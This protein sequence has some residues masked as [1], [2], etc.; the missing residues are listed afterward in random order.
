MTNRDVQ[1]NDFN[2]KDQS[3]K[4][5]EELQMR[6]VLELYTPWCI[7]LTKSVG[8]YDFDMSITKFGFNK[9][10]EHIAEDLGLIELERKWDD[11]WLEDWY[12][13]SILKRKVYDYDRV[14]EQWLTNIH[15]DGEETL[16]VK[17]D[18]YYKQAFAVTIQDVYEH[19]IK[20]NRGDGS[21]TDS[22]IGIPKDAPYV[23]HDLVQ[24]GQRIA[25]GFK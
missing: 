11:G 8:V 14:R 7:Q 3:F 9:K 2:L 21:Y 20:V 4:I 25:K 19:G 17:F 23:I 6:K 13:I 24:V 10:G 22:Y 1:I 15:R 5:E 18:K 16:F 12:E